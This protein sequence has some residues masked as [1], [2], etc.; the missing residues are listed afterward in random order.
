MMIMDGR[1]TGPDWS[2]FLVRDF[3]LVR[4]VIHIL[5][6]IFLGPVRGPKFGPKIRSGVDNPVMSMVMIVY[7][8]VGDKNFDDSKSSK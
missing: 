7:S 3:Y 2:G 1:I 6:R 8:A 5:V 4:Y